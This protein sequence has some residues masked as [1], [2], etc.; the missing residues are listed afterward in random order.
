MD[1]G[2]IDIARR[3]ALVPLPRAADGRLLLAVDITSWLRPEAHTCPQRILCHTCGRAKNTAHM[4]PGWPYSVVAALESGRSSWTTPLDA[5][6]LAPGDDAATVTAGQLRTVIGNLIEAGHWCPGGPEVWIIADA[7]YDAPRLAF[8]LADLPVAVLGR[9]R[10]DRVLRRRAPAWHPGIA[11]RPPRHGDEFAFG[12][13]ASWGEPDTA[14]RTGT[15]LYGPATARSWN[16]LHP[17]LTHR[18]SWVAQAGKLPV[19]E[20]TEIRLDVD[21]LPSARYRHRCGCGIRSS[22][23]TP[24]RSRCCGRHFCG[25]SISS[26]PSACSNRP[27]A[28]TSPNSATPPLQTDGPGCFSPLTPNC[29]LLVNSPSISGDPGRNLQPRNGLHPHVSVEGF[30]ASAGKRHVR[31]EHR[32]PPAPDRVDRPGTATSGQRHGTTCTSRPP[33]TRN[34][35]EQP[36]RDPVESPQNSRLEVKT[37]ARRIVH[38][39]ANSYCEC[40]SREP[41]TVRILCDPR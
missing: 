27:S 16:R 40:P 36:S 14:V 2:R 41:F 29:A 38:G 26:T 30:G 23:W 6:R 17:K 32:N 37:Q 5:V 4:I 7:G 19:I 9:M 35:S 8:L 20:G 12:D 10:S 22:T 28:G 15:R 34:L 13:Q 25:G 21:R 31:P 3:R 24:A 33:A 18:S 39:R 11:G 1:R